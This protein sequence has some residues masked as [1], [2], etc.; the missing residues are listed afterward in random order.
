MISISRKWF[1]RERALDTL[2]LTKGFTPEQREK[3][4]NETKT[5]ETFA[6]FILEL[7]NDLV[8]DEK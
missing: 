8:D 6:T 3:F 7:T 2:E 4:S 1:I 5:M